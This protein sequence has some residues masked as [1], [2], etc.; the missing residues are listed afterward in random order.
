V[1]PKKV[2]I[3]DDEYL[4]RWAVARTLLDLGY[5]VAAVGDGMKA[6]EIATAK[7]F[8]FVITDLDM[9]G[10]HGWELMEMLLK[11]PSPP[12]VIIITA[13]TEEDNRKKTTERG[14]WA[15][16][17]KSSLLIDSIKEVLTASP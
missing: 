14:G 9:P 2:L 12:R 17:E 7:R 4:I 3:V 6:L 5:E 8:D 1:E 10:L 13:G 15:Y 16:I 11:S